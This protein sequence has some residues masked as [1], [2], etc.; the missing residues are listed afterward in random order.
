VRRS[1][2]EGRIF[3]AHITSQE[4]ESLADQDDSPEATILHLN[5][6]QRMMETL[7][8]LPERTRLA[9]IMHIVDGYKLR[10]IA[11][12][13]NISLGQA[14]NLVKAGTLHCRHRLQAMRS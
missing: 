3:D 7:E 12:E 1:K 11:E 6:Y 8:E 14:H 13:L 9:V 10:T 5:E 4:I 2:R